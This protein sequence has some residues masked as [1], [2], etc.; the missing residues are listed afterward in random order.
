MAFSANRLTERLNA[1]AGDTLPSRLLVAFSG[2]MDSM[3]LLH[4]LSRCWR[5]SPLYALHID[6]GL[7][8]A[9]GTWA[10][11]AVRCAERLG[12][13][14]VVR[15]VSVTADGSGLEAAARTARYRA[16]AAELAPGDWLLTAHHQDDQAE[17]F[18]LNALR[19][20]GVRGLAAVPESR[21]CGSGRLLRPL[22]GE[23][24]ADL[25]AY[26]LEHELRWI[27]DPANEDQSFDR[28][29]LRHQVFPPLRERW[30]QAAAKLARSAELAR[31]DSDL[32]DEVAA[33]DTGN[34]ERL[35]RIDRRIID[36][37]STPRQRNLLRYL[38]R[39]LGLPPAPHTALQRVTD[40]LLPAPQDAEPK[41]SWRG[42][43]IRRYRDHLYLMEAL[44]RV[45]TLPSGRLSAEMPF[46]LGSGLGSLRLER[47]TDG[48]DPE[49]ASRGFAVRFRQ[50]GER[51]RVDERGGSRK[52]K[53]LL[54][55]AAIVPWMRSRVPLLTQGDRLIAVG[56]LW[57]CFDV[58]VPNGYV[59][60]WDARPP[61]H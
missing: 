45:D 10:R 41:V 5:R 34:V 15:K 50:G 14:C 13:E 21:P 29:W 22:L 38:L 26:A 57:I 9:S 2:G 19:G 48:I 7:D 53:A 35:E 24:R 4:A 52:L 56:D 49:L 44:P 12:I 28:N 43:E 1:L 18:L 3:V 23:S 27:D 58:L 36:P 32:L 46:A 25:L 20:S 47:A 51:L 42:A 61:L 33:Q 55:E 6:H 59:V 40:E 8:R 60:K 16:F 54:Q 37:L 31:S 17:T 39:Q 11:A 30:V